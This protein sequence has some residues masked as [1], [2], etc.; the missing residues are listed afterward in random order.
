MIIATAGHVDHGKTKLLHALTGINADRLPE[1]QQRGLTIDL[2]YAFMAYHS[3]KSN[4]QQRLGFIDVPGHEKFLSNMLAGVGTAHHAM[5]IV[6]GDEGMMPQ[7]YEHLTILR[8]LAMDSLTVVIT[9]SDLTSVEQ[10][11]QLEA[12]L[13]QLLFQYGFTQATIFHCSAHTNDGINALKQHLIELADNEQQHD[14][15]LN[16]KL[17]IDRAFHVKGSGLVV[18]GTAL[19][20][21]INV[22]DSLCLVSHSSLKKGHC[23]P[24]IVRIKSIH[25]QGQA[26]ESATANQR[27]ALNI[28]GD[29]DKA[30]LNRG[31]WLLHTAPTTIIKR[32]TVKLTANHLIKHWQNIQVFHAATHTTGRIALLEDKQLALGETALAEITLDTPLCLTE[33][34]RLL[35][36][37]PAQKINLGSAIVIDLLPPNRGKRTPQRLEYLNQRANL[38]ALSDIIEFKLQHAP[39]SRQKL[40][41]QH[42]CH[43]EVISQLLASNTAIEQYGDYLCFDSYLQALQQHIIATLEQYHQQ[44]QDTLG[45]GKDRLYRMTALNQPQVIF[46]AIINQLLNQQLLANTRGWLHLAAHQLQLTQSEL[47][48][49]HQI[50]QLMTTDPQPWWIRDLASEIGE[51]EE[52][53]RKLGYKLAQLSYVAAIVKDRYVTHQYLVKMATEVR[54][55]TAQYQKLETAEFRNISQLG[56]KVAIQLLEYFDKIGFTKRKFNYR[57][58]KDQDLLQD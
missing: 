50:E 44:A 13:S 6:A 3:E 9:K 10:Q 11:Q 40:L 39:Q 20:G 52:S 33:Q 43:T 2:G 28:S 49:W 8:L 57:E 14:N 15:T 5:L 54:Q 25:A 7:S 21:Q 56:R 31:D 24:N 36:R 37:D 41:E 12:T 18:T 42:Q 46:N 38:N 27:V 48:C 58:L 53:L 45:V 29:I 51:D 47:Q 30:S 35:L 4:Q 26:T 16:F 1:E 32:I 17:A 34:D 55:H 23:Q 19:N 22:G